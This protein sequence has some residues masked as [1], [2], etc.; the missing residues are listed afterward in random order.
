MGDRQSVSIS[1]N[2][3]EVDIVGSVRGEISRT[4]FFH[5]T[6][7]AGIIGF[8]ATA[9]YLEFPEGFPSMRSL[10]NY[11]VEFKRGNHSSGG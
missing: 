9:V 2:E 6:D 1:G 11:P 10:G 3:L 4:M 5:Q 8:N 7:L